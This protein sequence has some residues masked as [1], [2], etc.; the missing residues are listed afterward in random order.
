L[1]GETLKIIQDLRSA[2]LAVEFSLT[3]AKSDKQFKRAQELKAYST[4]KMERSAAGD[5]VARIRDP[6]T[7]T[8]TTV[9][10]TEAAQHLK[11]VVQDIAGQTAGQG[12]RGPV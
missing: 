6:R 7:R 5:L 8:E 1:R 11:S 12:Q 4:L 10:P 3:P 9:P 2:G